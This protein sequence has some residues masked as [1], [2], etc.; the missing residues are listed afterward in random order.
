MAERNYKREYAL[1]HGK[2]EEIARRS[3]RN[4]ARRE[5]EKKYGKAA[6]KGK[7]VDH[8]RPLSRGG[9]N[10]ASNLRLRSISSNRSDKSMIR[11]KII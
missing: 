7:D 9:G 4:K 6:L 3:A 5:M 11:K 10:S 2:P 8:V 1:F